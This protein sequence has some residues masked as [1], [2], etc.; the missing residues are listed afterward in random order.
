MSKFDPLPLG[1]AQEARKSSQTP[2]SSIIPVTLQFS[3]NIATAP[4]TSPAQAL[5]IGTPA[6][7]VMD[8]KKRPGQKLVRIVPKKPKI[9]EKQTSNETSEREVGNETQSRLTKTSDNSARN[10][11]ENAAFG[12]ES[13]GGDQD[14]G[15]G[16]DERKE[17]NGN[18]NSNGLSSLLGYDD[19]DDNDE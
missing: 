12:S 7:T 13:G 16:H 19:V 4:A 2:I 9:T 8:N 17:K 14:G 6:A 5:L 1:C 18:Q 15:H 3:K 10:R 11:I